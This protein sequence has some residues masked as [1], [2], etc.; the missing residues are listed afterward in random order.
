MSLQG[1]KLSKML[2]MIV[3]QVEFLVNFDVGEIEGEKE[4]SQFKRMVQTHKRVGITREMLIC[5]G[6]EQYRFE[7][8]LVR[9]ARS[10]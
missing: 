6:Q 2:H 7:F 9:G 10:Y 3:D 1:L 5:G 4:K 8:C